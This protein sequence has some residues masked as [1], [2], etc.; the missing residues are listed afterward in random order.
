MSQDCNYTADI[1]CSQLFCKQEIKQSKTVNVSSLPKELLS[2]LASSLQKAVYLAQEKG[3][4]SWLTALPVQEH[5]FSL[6]K[7]VFHDAIA[8]CYG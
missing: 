1:R 6:H 5:G 4:S 7:T 2:K 8:L 3:T